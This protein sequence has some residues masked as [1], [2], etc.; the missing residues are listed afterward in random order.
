M[1]YKEYLQEFSDSVAN[2]I[3]RGGKKKKKMKLPSGEI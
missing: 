3:Y 2:T 1:I